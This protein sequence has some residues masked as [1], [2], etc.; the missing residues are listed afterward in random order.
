MVMLFQG[1]ER[2]EVDHPDQPDT[3]NQKHPND[4]NSPTKNK[5]QQTHTNNTCAGGFLCVGL[6]VGGLLLFVI[7]C[8]FGGCCGG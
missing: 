4:K 7:V 8:Y 5:N 6:V 1:S 2:A 3:S